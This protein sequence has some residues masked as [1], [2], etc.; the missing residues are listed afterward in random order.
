M[1]RTVASN[2]HLK[3][4]NPSIWIPLFE[5]EI[6][7]TTYYMTPNPTSITYSGNSYTS[8]P[9]VLEEISDDGKGEITS[10]RLICSD[11]EGI[12]ATTLKASGSIDGNPLKFL[13]YSVDL[14]DVV[15]EENLEITK[16]SSATKETVSFEL[17]MF[18]PIT[19]KL[20]Q[21]KFISNF[22]WNMYKGK[23]CYILT[24]SLTYLP[25]ANFTVT[26]VGIG[27]TCS[28]IIDDCTLHGNVL[29][30]NGFPGIPGR[31]G[32]V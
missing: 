5:V 26:A 28:K 19:I 13:V 29:R 30:F 31:G 16:C 32:F 27:D 22:C 4:N 9:M 2:D 14:E 6:D 23:G 20:L 24:P 7:S 8:F 17:G 1:A 3:F 12:F 11:I 18:N 15:Y 10:A 25:P 21:Q